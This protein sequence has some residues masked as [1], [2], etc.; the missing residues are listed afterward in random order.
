MA[1]VLEKERIEVIASLGGGSHPAY[2]IE[3]DGQKKV[4]KEGKAKEAEMIEALTEM[5]VETARIVDARNGCLTL[6]YV[7]MPNLAESES[8]D[9][10]I[11]AKALADFHSKVFNN[12]E[13]L[14]NVLEQKPLGEIVKGKIK[15]IESEGF[16]ERTVK[17][18][19]SGGFTDYLRKDFDKLVVSLTEQIPD[20][21][22]HNDIRNHNILG[23][24]SRYVLIDMD[25]VGQGYFGGDLA[26][27]AMELKS[28]GKKIDEKRFKEV[29]LKKLDV[30]KT[31]EDL[32]KEYDLGKKL[33]GLWKATSYLRL[34]EKDASKRNEYSNYVKTYVGEALEAMSSEERDKFVNNLEV[35]GYRNKYCRKFLDISRE[36]EKENNSW[37]GRLSQ[38]LGRKFAKFALVGGLAAAAAVGACGYITKTNFETMEK[39]KA[40]QSENKA[41]VSYNKMTAEQEAEK[42]FQEWEKKDNYSIQKMLLNGLK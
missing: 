40:E 2:L 4:I 32:D 25:Q 22:G 19:F 35:N 17:S 5:G 37:V 39:I 23:N 24:G 41:K 30:K 7:D 6:E 18:V 29:Y 1:S 12:R 8:F 36:Y 9:Q 42:K 28:A 16:L 27:A 38:G 31:A 33:T 10:D 11:L 3:K 34:A 14:Q 20:E 26:R 15:D 13:K 21:V